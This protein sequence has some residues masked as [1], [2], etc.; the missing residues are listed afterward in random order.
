MAYPAANS[1][2]GN[3]I[4]FNYYKDKT[5]FHVPESVESSLKNSENDWLFIMES[6]KDG[7]DKPI[8]RKLVFQKGQWSLYAPL[9]TDVPQN[10][11][12]NV[13]NSSTDV[14]DN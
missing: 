9:E 4:R 2:C 12:D 10:Q 13:D 8:N 6:Q 3:G 14:S 5:L 1:V 7:F 11:S